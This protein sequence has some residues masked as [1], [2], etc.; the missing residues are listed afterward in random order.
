MYLHSLSYGDYRDIYDNVDKIRRAIRGSFSLVTVE[1][2]CYNLD[3]VEQT[4]KL[5]SGEER[6]QVRFFWLN[7]SK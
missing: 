5:L 1:F 7:F 4:K 6:K 2:H 3:E